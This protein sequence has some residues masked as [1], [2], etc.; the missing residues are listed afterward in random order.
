[1]DAERLAEIRRFAEDLAGRPDAELSGAGRTLL[2]LAAALRD[3]HEVE[4]GRAARMRAR[5][6]AAASSDRHDL[7]AAARGVLL[8]LDE[9]EQQ[10]RARRR[11]GRGAALLGVPLVAILSVLFARHLLAPSVTLRGP[12]DR[13]TLGSRQLAVAR[14]SARGNVARWTL[15]GRD[16]TARALSQGGQ[17][18]LSLVPEGSHT[19]AV[20]SHSGFLGARTIRRVRFTVDRTPPLV[21]LVRQPVAKARTPFE[22]AGT[23]AGAARLT[24]NG[25]PVALRGGSFSV[26]LAQPPDGVLVL[27]ASDLAGNRA[28][29]RVP[30]KVVPRHPA[31]GR[32]RRARDRRTRWADPT[33]RA[34]ILALIAPAPDQRG[35]ARPE[36]RGGRRR[37]RAA[38]PRA[39]TGSARRGRSSTC[40]RVRQLHAPR[41]PRDRPAGLLPRPDRSPRGLEERRRDEVVQ[42]PVG[43]PVRGLRRLH[44]LRD[45]GRAALPDRDRRR[46]RA[47]AG[48]DDI[49]YDYVRRPDGPIS[50]MVFPGLQ[51]TPEQRDRR[52]PARDAGGAPPLRHLPGRLGLRRRRDAADR[53]GA[54]RPGAWRARSTT[55]HRWSTRRTGTPASTTSPDPNRQPYAI[56]QRSLADF[57][58]DGARHRCARRAVAAGLLARRDVR[59]GAGASADQRGEARRDP[60]VPALGPGGHVHGGRARGRRTHVD[61]GPR[62]SPLRLLRRFGCER[63]RA[64]RCCPRAQEQR[65]GG[66]RRERE[67]RTDGERDVVA[68]C[69][70]GELSVAGRRERRGA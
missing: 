22:V 6:T 23:A 28:T 31:G 34:G 25:R 38:V 66:R 56:V 62:A 5:A 65:A 4:P 36:G 49:L 32:P 50:T 19:V 61:R 7:R 3:G 45:A 46:G 17:L 24:V 54:G 59:A 10:P 53:G 30:V 20:S 44:E 42:T 14:F 55:S 8:L 18:G 57:A 68:A 21:R 40:G 60:R 35:R 58:R 2:A 63:S 43:E 70:C 27:V 1:M 69:Q 39:P 29:S 64:C 15:D 16:V 52:V 41:R 51:G 33:L 11:P 67:H 12:A 37:L 48:V 13:S 47:Q 26:R 9:L